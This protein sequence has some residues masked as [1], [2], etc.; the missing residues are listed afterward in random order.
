MGGLA[1]TLGSAN[2]NVRSMAMDSEL[3]ILSDA[4]DVAFKLRCDLFS[5][6]TG[7]TG[8]SQFANMQKTYQ[9]WL[10]KMDDNSGLKKKGQVLDCQLLP[11]HVDRQPG[12]PLV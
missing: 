3:N 12:E 9:D 4:M 7:E 1:F 10:T 5:Q 11:F 6:C 8:P 2:L